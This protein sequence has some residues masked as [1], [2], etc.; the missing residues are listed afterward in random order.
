MRRLVTLV[1]VAA[2]AT[3]PVAAQR[4]MDGPALHRDTLDNGLQLLV[5]E[6]HAIPLATILVAV[7]NGSMTQESGDEGLAHLYEHLLFRSYAGDPSAFAQ[8]ATLL[9]GAYNG[10]TSEEV[11]TYY[12][13]LP[14][15]N[16]LKGITLLARLLQKPRFRAYDL[17]EELPV[18]L[19]ELQRDESDPESA[20]ERRVSQLLWGP[21]W[22]RK[23]VG[24]DSASLKGIT[25]E[26]LQ[27]TYA[28]YYVPNNAALVV[29]GDVTWADVRSTAQQQF[30]AWPRQPDPFGDRPIPAIAPLPATTA[31][32]LARPVAHAEI[33]VELQGPSVAQ[34]AAATYAAD[35]LCDVLNER[36]SPFQQDLV[37]GGLFQSVRC[38]YETLEHVGPLIFRG[39]T[40]PANAV[41]AL[42]ALLADLDQLNRLDGVTDE[43]LAMARE[44]RRVREAL[45]REATASL[46]PGLAT[47]W[48]STGIGY[49]ERY[50]DQVNAQRIDDLRRFAQAYIVARPRVI[51]VLAPSATI[52][53]VRAALRTA[54]GTPRSPR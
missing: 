12:V 34:D 5:V 4:P 9:D 37:A 48:A 28:R 30:G 18:V 10:S 2:F 3:G 49:Y 24:G 14:S 52:A 43:H 26:R 50:D 47:W 32:L 53:R 1:A 15:K 39:E 13:T 23:D 36:G 6:D 44:R 33:V 29:T 21:S 45:S 27:E 7:H 8:E 20:L 51:G 11:V 40:T 19:D 22:S 41:P 17:T 31:S 38:G 25:L 54:S 16:A 42:S 35:A 46:A